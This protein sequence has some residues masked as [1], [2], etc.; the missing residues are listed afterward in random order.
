[1]S[2]VERPWAWNLLMR[3]LRVDVGGG[4]TPLFALDKLAVFASLLPS[5]TFQSGPPSYMH[6]IELGGLDGDSTVH[7]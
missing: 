3:L 1:M 5:F 7:A 6:I 2:L 4:I